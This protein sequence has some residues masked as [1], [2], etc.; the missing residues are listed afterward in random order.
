MHVSGEGLNILAT[1]NF[2]LLRKLSRD[3]L[4]Q[5]AARVDQV[6]GLV[7]LMS[8]ARDVPQHLTAAPPIL[9]LYGGND[10]V[11]PAAPTLAVISDLGPKATIIHYPGGYH[12]LLR[13]LEGP[14]RWADVL[15]WI[16]KEDG[17]QT[18][19]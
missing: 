10:Q 3:P 4:F 5:H 13:D 6:Y 17:A 15:A 18:V 1:N 14:A 8:E 16:D 2:P 9:L 12:M 7:N 19:H 11:I